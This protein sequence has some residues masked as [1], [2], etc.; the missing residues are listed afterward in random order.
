MQR[1]LSL[2]ALLVALVVPGAG[3]LLA[4]SGLSINPY[5]G[6]YHFDESS[7]EEA[8][9][10]TDLDSEPPLLGVRLGVG[11]REGASLDLAYGR[12][13]VEGHVVLDDIVLRE[14]SS[15]HL[16]YAA[17]VYE[18]PIPGVGVFV[19]GG[20]GGVRY[21][22][23]DRD[24]RTDLLLNFGGGVAIP[25]GRLRIR[26]DAKDHVH[27]CEAPDSD[28][29]SD[30]SACFFDETLHNIELSAGVEIAL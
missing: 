7:F 18:L 30:F 29:F 22:P 16:F 23:E 4:Q 13:Q 11:D 25:I 10:E 26:A 1:S 17:L 24:T 2:T 28:E 12:A 21:D 5:V 20:A 19:S 3:P 6:Y 27:L 15:V 14:E 9:T 8:F